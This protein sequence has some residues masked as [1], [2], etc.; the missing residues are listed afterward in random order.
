MIFIWIKRNPLL[1]YLSDER[2][3]LECIKILLG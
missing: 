3:D 1:M 2:I